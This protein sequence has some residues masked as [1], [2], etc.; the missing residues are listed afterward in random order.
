M[1]S[2]TAFAPATVSNVACGFD[3]LGFALVSPGDEV[4]ARPVPSGV[5]IDDIIGDEGRLPREASR[6][7]AGVAAQALLTAAGASAR[8]RAHDP[9]RPAARERARR[10]RRQ[11][12]RRGRRRRRAVRAARV[13]RDAGH[14]CARRGTPRRRFGARRQHRAG[15]VRRLR[16]GAMRQS[17]R[18]RS[19]AG[20]GRADRGRR[21]SGSR[22]RDGDGPHPARGLGA[23]EGRHP[24]V[25]Q[26]R[27]VR[28]RTPSRRLRSDRPIARRHHRRAAPRPAG[29]WPGGDQARRRRRR[30][31]WAAACPD[32]D[33]RSS[34]CAAMPAMRSA[35]RRP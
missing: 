9:Q 28:G 27:R 18:H 30:A 20:A 14:L 10:Q 13:H 3:V 17:A 2:V 12:R 23:V 19:P 21:P 5:S 25:G 33:R 31:H 22:D 7:T 34:R 35:W 11:R 24:A 32:P 15:A 29:A 1:D 16:A 4:T 6:N 26:P 8:R